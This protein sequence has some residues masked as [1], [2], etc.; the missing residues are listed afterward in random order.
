MTPDGTISRELA[1]AA[2]LA[3]RMA[4]GLALLMVLAVCVRRAIITFAG[5]HYRQLGQRKW[6]LAGA[7][8]LAMAL[9]ELAQGP[10]EKILKA[11]ADAIGPVAVIP[12]PGWLGDALIALYH[13]GAATLALVL[14]IQ[15]VGALYWGVEGRLDAWRPRIRAAKGVGATN[16]T[17]FP[18]WA[19]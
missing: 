13:T 5:E 12:D 16:S 9:L 4:L 8:L 19:T 10:V 18:T 2:F 11:L 15:L 17:T 3:I 6:R 7:T 14:A 1:E